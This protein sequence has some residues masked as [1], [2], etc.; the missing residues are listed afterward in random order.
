M[1]QRLPIVEVEWEDAGSHGSWDDE[2]SHLK[3]AKPL[4]CYSVGYLASKRADR[5]ILVASR[6]SYQDGSNWQQIPRGCIRSMR[7]VER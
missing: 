5:I 3:Q 6:A 2:D 7:Y 1:K 4:I